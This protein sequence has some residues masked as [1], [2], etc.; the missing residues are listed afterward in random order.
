MQRPFVQIDTVTPAASYNLVS[1][2]TV[3]TSLNIT[4]PTQETY[5]NLAIA[6][7]SGIAAS[8]C[9][10][11]FV[12]EAIQSSYF[13]SRDGFPWIVRDRIAPL[14]LRRYPVVQPVAS[15]VETIAGAATTLIENTDFLVDYAQGTI[16]RLDSA[17]YPR[18]WSPNPIVVLYSA[19]YATIPP[20]VI[21]A[22]IDI[23]RTEYYGR[24]RDPLLRGENIEGVYSAQYFFGN[25]PG[26]Q[27]SLPPSIA[28][29]LDK[30][31]M[32]AFG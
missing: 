15:V 5:L 9:N 26:T 10:Q 20:S 28:G 25:G 32:P 8:Y 4:D 30:Y 3:M 31:R 14:Q 23:V 1:L 22:V 6:E 13:P 12:I 21:K 17:G 19:G 27:K 18:L 24:T 2:A 7:A 11:P 16:T 29:L